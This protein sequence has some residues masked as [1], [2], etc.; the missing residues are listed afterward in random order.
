M[1][2]LGDNLPTLRRPIVTLTVI[3]ATAAVW[4]VGQGAGFNDIA[5]ATSVCNFG[6]VPGELTGQA[7][8]GFAVPLAEGLTCNVDNEPI[9]VLTPAMWL[10]GQTARA[11]G[12]HYKTLWLG[13][14]AGARV[15]PLQRA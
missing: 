15:I 6:L 10:G 2:P 5:L 8:L 4:L 1:I 9:N 13:L 14:S 3:G 11:K 12:A 7:A